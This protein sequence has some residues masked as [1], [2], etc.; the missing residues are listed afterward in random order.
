MIDKE[1][2]NET[3]V[4]SGKVDVDK[5]AQRIVSE[6][7]MPEFDK[8]KSLFKSLND[9][10]ITVFIRS[11]SFKTEP[12]TSIFPIPT[13]P[14]DNPSEFWSRVMEFGRTAGMKTDCFPHKIPP[15]LF[16]FKMHY[17]NK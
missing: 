17:G 5:E 8:L 1:K 11:G 2:A 13:C 15:Y 3:L 6:F 7:L 16:S 12:I 10:Q 14:T 9:F 4:L